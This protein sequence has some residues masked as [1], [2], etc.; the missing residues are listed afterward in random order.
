MSKIFD[1]KHK[2]ILLTGGTGSF[3]HK[4]TEILLKK[5]QPKSLRIF[6]RDE[7]KQYE[8]QQLFKDYDNL[9]FFVGDVRDKERVY[10]AMHGVDVVIHA[11][12]LKHVPILEYNPLEAVKTNVLGAENIIN[13]AI[14][15]GVSRIMA[16]R[17]S[18]V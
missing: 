4:C 1:L 16:D 2:T 7:L 6:S 3:G 12:A 17:K 14:D 18:V 10:R 5:Y 13:A 11:A 9:R 15:Q 8:M